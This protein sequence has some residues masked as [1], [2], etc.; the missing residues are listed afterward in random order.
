MTKAC[1]DVTKST[2]KGMPRKAKPAPIDPQIIDSDPTPAKEEKVVK[3]LKPGTTPPP[4]E[5]TFKEESSVNSVEN[6]E[7]TTDVDIVE[8]PERRP[9]KKI[10]RPVLS[11]TIPAIPVASFNRLVREISEE[12]KSDLR[13]EGDALRALQVDTEAYLIGKFQNAKKTLDLFGKTS[14]TVGENM[15]RA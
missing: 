14:R 10:R 3:Q 4:A 6:T 15:L 1:R 11:D 2:Q 7:D 8:K 13:W 9:R 5:S 12:C